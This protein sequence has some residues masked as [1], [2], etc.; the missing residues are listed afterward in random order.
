MTVLEE[1]VEGKP[2]RGR[3]Q[4]TQK[5]NIKGWTGTC[6]AESTNSAGDKKGRA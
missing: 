2:A 1:K 4:Y 6:L 3:Q 5:N